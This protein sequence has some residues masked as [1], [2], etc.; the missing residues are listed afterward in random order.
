[1]L[2]SW[3]PDPDD[4]PNFTVICAELMKMLELANESYNYVDAVKNNE[5]QID[6]TSYECGSDEE[7]TV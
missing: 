4:R 1:M 3:C 7:V 2:N 6:M 5:I